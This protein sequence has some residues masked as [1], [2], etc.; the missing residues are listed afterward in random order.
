VTLSDPAAALASLRT[1]EGWVTASSAAGRFHSLFGRDALVSALQLLPVEPEIAH[2]TLDRLGRE[3][4][5]RHDPDTEEEP[6]KVLHEARD[7][8]LDAYVAHGWPVRDGRLRYWGSVDAS[9]WFLVLAAALARAGEPVT[10]HRDAVGRVAAWVSRQ[11]MPIT[12]VRRAQRGGLA[13]HWW[14]DVAADLEGNGH[15]ILDDAGRPLRTPAALAAVQALAWR[16][17]TEVS[18][19][20]DPYLAGAADRARAAFEKTFVDGRRVPSTALSPAGIDASVTS[21]LGHVL[22]T[23]ILEPD[24]AAA[25]A[26]RLAA[27]DLL[28]PWGLRTL[29]SVHPG[30]RPDG[31]HTGAVWAW[32]SWIGA[33]GLDAALGPGAGDGVRRG[34][35]AAV[36][37]LGDFPELWVV[38]LDG[39]LHPSTEAARVQAWTVGAVVAIGVGWD[40]RAWAA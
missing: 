22:W 19:T 8:D 21:D 30:F 24:R 27:P 4:G 14:R 38:D 23:G 10:G 40:G 13:H 2:A 29:S 18:E 7:R 20:F 3:L 6:G 9:L 37:A 39:T 11:P 16:A 25:T 32:D 36:G 17:L 34:V 26:E 12:Y 1:P 28:T 15:G 31:Y 5:R 35:T 33:A